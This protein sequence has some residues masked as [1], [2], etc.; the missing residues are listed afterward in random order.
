MTDSQR[1]EFE[2][3]QSLRYAIQILSGMQRKLNFKEIEQRKALEFV[4]DKLEAG[5]QRSNKRSMTLNVNV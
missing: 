2:Y 4:I 5:V 1:S 3:R